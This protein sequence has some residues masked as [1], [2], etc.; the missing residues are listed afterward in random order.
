MKYPNKLY[1]VGESFVG[2]ML[3]LADMI[4]E[5]GMGIENIFYT[6]NHKMELSDFV[7]ALTSMY[8][9]KKIEITNDNVI[10]KVC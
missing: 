8:M 10:Y 9:L 6:A 1:S 7:D 3:I 2:K 4:P 5:T